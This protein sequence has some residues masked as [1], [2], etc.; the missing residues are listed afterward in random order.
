MPLNYKAVQ[1][2]MPSADGK[3]KYHPH[4]VKIHKPVELVTLATEIAERS[5]LT[6][7]DVYNVVQNLI[8]S[9]K[10]HLLNGETVKLDGLGSFTVKAHSEGNGVDT[11]EEVNHK[12]ISYLTIQFTPT[13]KRMGGMGVLKPIFQGVKFQRIDKPEK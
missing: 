5:S 10:F 2:N 6:P 13:Y 8:G 9:M 4:L 7:G 12:Q 11:P 1:S 3:K